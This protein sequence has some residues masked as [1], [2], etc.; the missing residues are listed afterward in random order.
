MPPLFRRFLQGLLMGGADIIPGVSG[1][2]M[3][4]IVG[5]YKNLIAAI[6]DAFSAVLTLLRGRF[7]EALDQFRA[8]EWS[9]LLPVVVGIFVAIGLGSLF[10][11]ELL[12]AYPVQCRAVFLGLVAASIVIPWR[13]RHEHHTWH[14]AVA[15]VAAVIAFFLV[16]LPRTGD[17]ADPSFLRIAGTAAVAINAMI[18]PGVS[19]AFLLEVFGLYR[20]TLEALRSLDVA[21]V[22]TFALGAGIGLGLAAKAL[23][24]LLDRYHDLTMTVLV[25]LLAGSLR[26]LWPWVGFVEH[27]G[28]DGVVERVPDPSSLLGPGADPALLLGG[29]GVGWPLVLGLALAG[30]AFVTGLTW[31]GRKR[32]DGADSAL[33]SEHRDVHA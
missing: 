18:L 20:P 26:A 7:G 25:G 22:A 3:A 9:L 6:G 33:A 23:S 4:L 2:T 15:V 14:L 21:F 1:G 5:I 12:E 19:G 27:T 29:G 13:E 24:W 30:F 8:L 10:V 32:L 11:P 31:I 16:G 17:A 28:S